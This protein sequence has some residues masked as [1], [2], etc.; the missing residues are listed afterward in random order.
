MQL[1]SISSLVLSLNFW[2]MWYYLTLQCWTNVNLSFW[3]VKF[4][5]KVII[6]IIIIIIIMRIK[7]LDKST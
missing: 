1:T 7:T 5:R 2:T 6:I 3:K 4:L